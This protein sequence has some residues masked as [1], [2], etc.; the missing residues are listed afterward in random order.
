MCVCFGAS[1]FIGATRMHDEDEEGAHKHWE[2]CERVCSVFFDR[3]DA[4]TGVDRRNEN[5]DA[6][7]GRVALKKTTDS[8]TER[9]GGRIFRN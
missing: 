3:M 6:P 4:G 7:Y 1:P 5:P 9:E 2:G 8:Y